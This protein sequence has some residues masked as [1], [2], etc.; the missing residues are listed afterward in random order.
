MEKTINLFRLI[1][2]VALGTLLLLVT[3]IPLITN[4]TMVTSLVLLPTF[5]IFIFILSI[6]IEQKLDSILLGK[7][8]IKMNSPCLIKSCLY[9]KC[10]C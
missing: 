8:T 5:L 10:F 7:T 9:K 1:H 2:K 3:A 4:I 6:L